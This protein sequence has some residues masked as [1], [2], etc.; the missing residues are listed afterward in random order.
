[1]RFYIVLLALSMC[2]W[3]AMAGVSG[4][5]NARVNHA[6]G[7]AAQVQTVDETG[8]APAVTD[9]APAPAAAAGADT[10]AATA[11]GEA[12]LSDAVINGG[13]PLGPPPGPRTQAEEKADA[14]LA[15][16]EGCSGAVACQNSCITTGYNV[17]SGPVPAITASIPPPIGATVTATT[18]A[19]TTT[20]SVATNKPQGSGAGASWSSCGGYRMAG[21]VAVVAVASFFVGL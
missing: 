10:A 17:P 7:Q 3:V 5:G 11:S 12:T 20:A 21:A 18:V 15:C 14:V 16:M 6:G 4:V 9:D 2:A 13:T 1:M 19:P 8:A